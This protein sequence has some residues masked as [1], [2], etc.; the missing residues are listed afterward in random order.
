LVLGAW[1]FIALAEI[2]EPDTIFY[3]KIINRTSG[4]QYL[5]T[6]GALS[7]LI[8]RPD[9]TQITLTNKLTAPADGI[10]YNLLVP[11]EALAY[12]LTVSPT[13]VPLTLQSAT[14]SHLQITVNG[15]AATIMAPGSTTFA[16]SQ[17]TRGSS[18]RLDLELFN[19]L[20]DTAGDGI[21][22]WWKAKYGVVDPNADPDGDG[23]SNLQEFL[24][25]ANPTNDNR[26][27]SLPASE[28]FV[29]S[30]GAT[31]IRLQ[32]IDSD[33]APTNL[34][35]TLLAAPQSGTLYLHNANPNPTNSDVALASGSGFTQ[36]DV[37]KG[38]L[39][40]R[41]QSADPSV[42]ADSF[43]VSLHDETPAHP[44]STNLVALNI[45]LPNY[46][47]ATMQQ[48]QSIAVAPAG[49]T[50]IAG[51]SFYEQQMLLNYC[52][53]RDHGYVIW[54]GS[55]ASA[56]QQITATSSGL[57]P[58]QYTQYVASYGHD[59][60]QVLM[61]GAGG[62]HL[63][64]GMENDVLIGG[65]GTDS[66][67]G[68]G[69]ADLFVIPNSAGSNDTIEDFTISDHDAIDIS[70][71]LT[72]SSIWLTNYVQITSSG[73]NSYLNINFNGDGT[74]YSNMVITLLG[75]QLSQSDLRT[76]VENGN[77]IT[78]SKILP[79]RLSIAASVP[80]ASQ[81]G[82]V[83]GQFTITRFGALSM[84][85]TANLQITGSAVNGSDYQYIASTI[86]FNPGQ[87]SATI[88]INPYATAS[89]FT[90]IVQVAII[91]GAGYDIGSP[92]LAQV[93]IAPTLP[94]ISIQTLE[95]I[96]SRVDQ[97]AGLF[98]VSRG[99]IINN[100]VLVRLTIGGTAPASHYNSI[101]PFLNLTAN[102]T[103]AL[104]SVT[105]KATA[106]LSNGLESVQISIK[107]DPSYSVMSPSTDR[108]LLI[109][110]IMTL[111][112]WQQKYFPGNSDPASV[113]AMEDPGNTGIRN[114]FR[115]AYGL[116][117]LTP[118]NSGARLPSYQIINDHLTVSYKEPPAISDL[119]YFVEVSDDLFNWRSTTN[120]LEQYFPPG[121][122]NDFE[123][124]FFR[125]KSAVSQTQ[126]LFMRVRVGEQ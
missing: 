82:P 45:Y 16:V 120:D 31:G 125:S 13:A 27:P 55:R 91:S 84:G 10:S 100:S 72:G 92:A 86:T 26:L 23:W 99:G 63:V 6:Q 5:L 81:N 32:A 117:P 51:L 52:L 110:Q 105:P 111:G 107:P 113:F 62:D 30:G 98:L 77:L 69:G 9:G 34:F 47:T 7:W 54:D 114:L 22:D 43:Q 123:T 18:Y 85:F 89:V 65:R 8:K 122:S 57:T 39:I 38:R 112:V 3:G 95:P 118:Q 24:M 56:P 29:Y 103:T 70:R 41:H 59:S 46:S 17:A 61:A 48:A 21:P 116:N 124:V 109:D 90:Q 96:A 75:V 88:S 20:A 78:G 115:Y 76:L 68:N 28:F 73:T 66:L 12:G 119:N 37:N 50:D 25:G 87:T 97:T 19:P 121:S 58:S 67:R 14:C 2:P 79:P 4:Q 60:P 33:S 49:F 11:H 104:I 44:A 15:A 42:T 80:A 83:A 101:S 36:D 35:Y 106:V 93:S 74:G 53:S 71:V 108:V 102:Q 126:K 1:C 64:G 40:F 94:Q